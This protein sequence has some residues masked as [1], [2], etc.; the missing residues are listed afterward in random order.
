MKL[1]FGNALR[2]NQPLSSKQLTISLYDKQGSVSPNKGYEKQYFLNSNF[3]VQSAKNQPAPF[4]NTLTSKSKRS[5]DQPSTVKHNNQPHKLRIIP[6][7][8]IS[9]QSPT[10]ECPSEQKTL[11]KT[12]LIQLA[13]RPSEQSKGVSSNS[14]TQ[15]IRVNKLR[16]VSREKV[17]TITPAEQTELSIK[18]SMMIRQQH[19]AGVSPKTKQKIE[20][21]VKMDKIDCAKARSIDQRKHSLQRNGA[22]ED[23]NQTKYMLGELM[24]IK[25]D[26]K[27]GNK[28][29]SPKHSLLSHLHKKATEAEDVRKVADTIRSVFNVCK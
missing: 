8:N 16:I 10:K 25:K 29:S 12:K 15:Q 6:R 21:R 2:K 17:A 7:H 9:K 3:N 22:S 24:V 11:N 13:E 28:Q 27:V 19:T 23:R 4:S 5:I 14:I 20:F 18:Q 1:E 26:S